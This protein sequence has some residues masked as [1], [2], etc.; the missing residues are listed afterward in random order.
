[1]PAITPPQ[2]VMRSRASL[3]SAC[4]RN[5]LIG[6]CLFFYT[7]AIAEAFIWT[8]EPQQFMA[9]YIKGTDWGVRGNIPNAKYWHRTPEVDVEYRINRQGMRA[10][11]EYAITKPLGTCRIALFGDSFFIGYE[12][13]LED[14]FGE[15]L[16]R[17]LVESGIKAEVL[18]FSVSGFGTA[19]MIKTYEGY[20][21]QFDPDLVIF[22]WHFTDAAD[23][24]RSD[25]FRV[26]EGVLEPAAA[27]YPSDIWVHDLLMK[28]AIYRFVDDHS[29]VYRF[30]EE[31][32]VPAGEELLV[33]AQARLANLQWRMLKGRALEKMPVARLP[34]GQATPEAKVL[35]GLILKYAN[36]TVS[37][38]K[39]S[40]MVIDIP[41]PI[42]RV[43][44]ESAVDLIPSDYRANLKLVSPIED[45]R[46]AAN[47]ERKLYFE[48]GFGHFTPLGIEVLLN[49]VFPSIAESPSLDACRT[50]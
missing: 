18:N 50:Q 38:D 41:R 8:F 6:V 36:D 48:K 15:R 16:E 3:V 7:W 30:V 9:R 19:E 43:S 47:P 44:F 2:A 17:R 46:S 14:T 37:N 31:K 34:L 1:M 35:S 33:R 20:G 12:L 5:A 26:S 29:Q 25:L 21:R 22:S 42:S 27:T 10:D 49:S 23:N 32:G 28:S 4:A 39:R 11:R 40:F 24:V 45:L 13:N